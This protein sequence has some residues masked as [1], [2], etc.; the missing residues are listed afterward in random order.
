MVNY[1]KWERFN[2][3]YLI[4]MK[5]IIPITIRDSLPNKVS[6]KSFSAEVTD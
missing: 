6:V 1:D 3:M 4:V 5:H 2:M